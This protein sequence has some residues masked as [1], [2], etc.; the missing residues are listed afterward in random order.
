MRLTGTGFDEPG[1]GK[2]F[3]CG[4]LSPVAHVNLP[5]SSSGNVAHRKRRFGLKRT[6]VDIHGARMGF[7]FREVVLVCIP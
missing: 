7:D 1:G 3:F 2:I 5:K 6:T 4:L